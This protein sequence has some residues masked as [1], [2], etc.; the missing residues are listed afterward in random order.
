MTNKEGAAA[1][2]AAAQ[3]EG[4]KL[5]LAFGRQG[6]MEDAVV[7]GECAL[8]ECFAGTEIRVRIAATTIDGVNPN[9]LFVLTNLRGYCGP[10]VLVPWHLPL[11]LLSASR[12]S[13]WPRT[14]LK[15]QASLRDALFHSLEKVIEDEIERVDD[16]LRGV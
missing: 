1:L 5:V 6:K 3:I 7:I 14:M 9:A 12:D 10:Y 2:I 16:G 15:A 11:D 8:R 13:H 4:R